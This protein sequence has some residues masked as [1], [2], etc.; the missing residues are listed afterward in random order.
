[1]LGRA[2]GESAREST[3]I[4][5]VSVIFR[6]DGSLAYVRDDYLSVHRGGIATVPILAY[7]F[8]ILT[9]QGRFFA[10]PIPS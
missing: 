7:S 1:L 6:V 5:H 9:P 10:W 2:A 8:K 3:Q 4:G